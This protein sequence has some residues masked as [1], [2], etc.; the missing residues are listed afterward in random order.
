MKIRKSIDELLKIDLPDV[1]RE[2]LQSVNME[3]FDRKEMKRRI[4]KF[5]PIYEKY[6]SVAELEAKTLD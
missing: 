3:L 5:I 2:L 4:L 1:S 6:G